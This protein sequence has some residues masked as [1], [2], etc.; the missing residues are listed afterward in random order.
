MPRTETGQSHA[1]TVRL[2]ECLHQDRT[3]MHRVGI[4]LAP[5]R[6]WRGNAVNQVIGGYA[7]F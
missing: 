3:R 5:A 7:D 2:S 4:F 6:A 1:E